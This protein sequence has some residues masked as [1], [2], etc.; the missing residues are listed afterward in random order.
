MK[1]N[2]KTFSIALS[3]NEDKD[4][5]MQAI[6]QYKKQKK[7][8]E[9]SLEIQILVKDALK[10]P[11][12]TIKMLET[13]FTDNS[14][15][16]ATCNICFNYRGIIPKN[17]LIKMQ[18]FNKLINKKFRND[19]KVLDYNTL[20]SLDEVLNACNSIYEYANIC[21]K[22]K[23]S[24]AEALLYGYV[25]ATTRI[26]KREEPEENV[27][28]SRSI[29]GVL[30]SNNIVCAGYA[31][32][33]YNFIKATYVDN[34]LIYSNTTTSER[35]NN[36]IIGHRTLLVYLKDDKY[37]IDGYYLLDP[38][39][40]M[41]KENGKINLNNFL[42]PINDIYT[43][44]ASYRDSNYKRE[45]RVKTTQQLKSIDIEKNGSWFNL[46]HKIVSLSE[47]GFVFSGE[48]LF[49]EFVA[50]NIKINKN[51]DALVKLC[52]SDL[53][54]DEEKRCDEIEDFVFENSEAIPYKTI[55]KLLYNTLTK[56]YSSLEKDKVWKMTQQIMN[57]STKRAKS[58]YGI[59]S[60]NA[61]FAQW[62]SEYVHRIENLNIK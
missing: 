25:F 40:D 30:N 55:E 33:I 37:G 34:I 49:D 15:N 50:E 47:D 44:K 38:T 4:N 11:K 27:G 10:N 28:W 18:E 62:Y 36:K 19:V 31:E 42:I 1:K 16:P 6:S 43:S 35:E 13:F 8:Q 2:K 3:L 41:V 21:N 60:S 48:W 12:Q 17:T 45:E 14:I 5:V 24:P 39:R 29:Y 7:E 46:K 20:F 32:L 53:V 26:Y 51:F 58:Q 52:G 23:L 59:D 9:L 22:N 57:N 56:T 61:F 54:L